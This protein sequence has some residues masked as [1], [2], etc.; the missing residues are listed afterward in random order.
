M[1][2][3]T[4]RENNNI[5]WEKLGEVTALFPLLSVCPADKGLG[6]L[7]FSS[8]EAPNEQSLRAPGRN[9][10]KTVFKGIHR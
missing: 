10:L 1:V 8:E 9:N 7:T 6:D 3:Q 4:H 5:F 2:I